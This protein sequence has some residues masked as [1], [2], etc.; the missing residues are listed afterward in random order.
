MIKIIKTNQKFEQNYLSTN[1]WMI[2]TLHYL[3]V[4]LGEGCVIWQVKYCHIENCTILIQSKS[5]FFMK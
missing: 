3:V 5:E 1:S 2:G 4:N